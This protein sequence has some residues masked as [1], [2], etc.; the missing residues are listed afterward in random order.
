MQSHCQRQGYFSSYQR[1]TEQP[2]R[3]VRHQKTGRG[4]N[5]FQADITRRCGGCYAGQGMFTEGNA[6]S[7]KEWMLNV[8]PE[9][10]Q[11]PIAPAFNK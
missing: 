6:D 8:H 3:M 10:E 4:Q 1:E 7:F 5:L 2:G 9:I 11:V